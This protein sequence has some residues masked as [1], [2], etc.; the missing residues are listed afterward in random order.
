MSDLTNKID[1]LF[2]NLSGDQKK[3][4][5]EDMNIPLKEE[6]KP[7]A[8]SPLHKN[9]IGNGRRIKREILREAT[10]EVTQSSSDYNYIHKTAEG[11]SKYIRESDKPVPK[12]VLTTEETRDQKLQILENEVTKLA[13]MTRASFPGDSG[14]NLVSGI[15][16]GGDGQTPG[17][18]AVWLWDLD[19]VDIGSPHNGTYPTIDNGDAILYDETTNTWKPGSPGGSYTL[20]VAT[21]IRLG[22]I[23]TGSS[24][25]AAA[26]G[27]LSLS[28]SVTLPGNMITTADN[29]NSIGND[30]NYFQYIYANGLVQKDTGTGDKVILTVRN[31]QIILTDITQEITSSVDLGGTIPDPGALENVYLNGSGRYAVGA[32][33]LAGLNTNG[34][35][36]QD[37]INTPGQFFVIND[38]DGGVFG[39]GDRQCF[40]LIRETLFDAT[41]LDGGPALWSGGNS[42]AWSFSPVWYY[43]GGN[44]YIWTS[45]TTTSQS[46]G[47]AGNAATGTFS[48]QTS[49]REWWGLCE[50]AEVGKRV[51]VGIANGTSTDQAGIDYT[52]RL[53]FQL[54][55]SA[56]M[57]AH[58][59]AAADLPA[60][61]I[62]KGAG[63][64]TAWATTGEYENMGS[65]PDGVDKGYR[66][67]WSTF[68][69]TALSQLPY[70]TGVST[71]DQIASATGLVYYVV[72][73]PTAADI[74]AAN[75]VL[76]NGTT[77]ANNVFFPS[78]PV[79][80][81]QFNQ[82]Y[83]SFTTPEA[84]IFDL[85][86]TEAGAVQQSP[87]FNI[88]PISTEE[89]IRS[90]ALNAAGIQKLRREVCDEILDAVTGYYLIRDLDVADR[91][92]ASAYW[93]DVLNVALA[94]QLQT[95]YDLT[96]AKT[97]TA[98]AP[99]EL[100]DAVT[101]SARLW[102]NTFPVAGSGNTLLF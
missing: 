34:L 29:V 14:R 1:D 78:V 69:N 27:T 39:Y 94:G 6:V 2:E 21:D 76:S 59:D 23:M 28:S 53:I 47:G 92:T 9:T 54:Y 16:Q 5:S 51:R 72:Y 36:T 20:P 91:T 12:P 100:L 68:G 99:Q 62:T 58:P 93:A 25:S 66:F 35:V 17:S 80:L 43:V 11:L 73:D 24:F 87:M 101:N 41:D 15:G 86:Y 89:E 71:N 82:P 79:K 67:R 31:N 98:L 64:Y 50:K 13:Q 61:C 4:A 33:G 3:E 56:E 44:P 18:G 38:I 42:G 22:G 30:T 81:L 65:F 90:S 83:T 26:D 45:Y 55:V 70:V 75:V 40:G 52:N 32:S 96:I 49:Q 88:Y 95:V 7:P 74:A 8:S 85:S 77:S 97:A 60:L 37:F 19:D 63:Y 10:H 57:L 46:P 84:R 48:G 102:I